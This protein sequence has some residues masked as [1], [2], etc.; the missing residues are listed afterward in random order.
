MANSV[1]IVALK[2]VIGLIN[3]QVE[4]AEAALVEFSRNDSQKAPLLQCMWSVHLITSSLRMLGIR[5]GEMLSLEMERAINHLYT[6]K[7]AGERRKLAM[8]GLMQGLAI[9]PAYLSHVQRVRLDDGRGLE[10]YVNDL[11]RW[12]G[13]RPR[14]PAHFFRIDYPSGAGI[15]SDASPAPDAEIQQSANMMLALY[16]EMARSALR[17]INTVESMKIVAR[18]ARKMQT[19]FAG[20]PQER[21]WFTLIGICEG[22]AGGLIKPDECIAQILKAG[23]FSIKHAREHGVAPASDIDYDEYQQEMLYFISACRTRPVHIAA[24]WR[25]FGIDEKTL[26]ESRR[27]LVHVDALVTAIGT[28]LERIDAA[29]AAV[30]ELDVSDPEALRSAGATNTAPGLIEEAQLRLDAARLEDHVE[31]L[32]TVLVALR[33]LLA[34]GYLA[35]RDKREQ[36]VT[37]IVSGLVDVKLDLEFK[38]RHDVRG[39]H[40][41]KEFELCEIVVS[42][43]FSQMAR[44]AE[45]L[46]HLVRRKN[47]AALLA[48]PA[49][50]DVTLPLCI[51]LQGFL[52][53]IEGGYEELRGE[54]EAVQAG[55]GD[56]GRLSDLARDFLGQVEQSEA[57]EGEV[58]ASVSERLLD[59]AGALGFVG[60]TREEAVIEHCYRWL[61]SDGTAGQVADNVALRGMA[62]AFALLELHLQRFVLDPEEDTSTLLAWA[63]QCAAGLVGIVPESGPLAAIEERSE[64]DRAGEALASDLEPES[65]VVPVA[66]VSPAVEEEIDVAPVLEMESTVQDSAIPA[67]FREAFIEEAE[68]ICAELQQLVTNWRQNRSDEAC[69]RDIRRH[70]HSFKGNGRAVGANVL[71]ELGWAAQD[72]LDRVIDG[73]KQIDDA[74]QAL[75]EEVIATLPR[76]VESYREDDGLDE[77]STRELTERC[78]RQAS[79]TGDESPQEQSGLTGGGAGSVN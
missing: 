5:K 9:M 72:M 41:D 27:D 4:L 73:G 60:M 11:R 1:D 32:Q 55:G 20:T 62:D 10:P 75:L 54:L 46:Q 64:A 67:E 63:E 31:S 13:E 47:L 44:V 17:N 78:F 7:V 57:G 18:I 8:G 45:S 66:A 29:I 79:A 6:D 56:V 24:V 21:F 49:D 69:L 14:S 50:S 30:V 53:S 71:G 48:E 58:L 22:L 36:T 39:T 15:S 74:L 26:A 42:A 2:R 65:E 38:L 68:E 70:F 25:A 33:G 37:S 40:Y 35:D 34:G 28:A 77:T 16:L 19:L 12:L 3:R 23:A 43:T 76:L 61:Q 51:S 52:N 59:I